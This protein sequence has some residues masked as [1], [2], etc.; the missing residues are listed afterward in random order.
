LGLTPRMRGWLDGC[1]S[2]VEESPDS[3]KHGAG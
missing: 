2:N 1:G 3:K